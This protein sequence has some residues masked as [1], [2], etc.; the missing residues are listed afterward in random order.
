[1]DIP[2]APF[3]DASAEPLLQQ[4]QSMSNPFPWTSDSSHGLE[5]LSSGHKHKKHKSM[6]LPD[7]SF[8]PGSHHASDTVQLSPPSSPHATDAPSAASKAKHGHRRT[9]S[10]L[11]GVEPR[12]SP[13][14]TL[15]PAVEKTGD[16]TAAPDPPASN[17]LA[18]KKGHKHRRSAAVSKD[19]TGITKGSDAL[20]ASDGSL[21]LT[22]Q[23][24]FPGAPSLHAPV[25]SAHTTWSSSP[26]RSSFGSDTELGNNQNLP[27]LQPTN[28][29]AALRP[30]HSSDG[31]ATQTARPQLSHRSATD[32]VSLQ[33]Y[34]DI[35]VEDP[36]FPAV[37]IVEHAGIELSPFA[38]D[39]APVLNENFDEDPTSTIEISH[40][41]TVSHP[42]SF[43]SPRLEV[44]PANTSDV[45]IDLDSANDV[46]ESVP[47]TAEELRVLRHKSFSAARRSMHSGG[48]DIPTV[49]PGFPM[50]RRTES[51]PSLAVPLV[52]RPSS[53]RTDTAD[54]ASE[55]GFEMENVFEE[56]EEEL[57]AAREEEEQ[58]RLE[59]RRKSEQIGLG[60]GSPMAEGMSP[61][62][63]STKRSSVIRVEGSDGHDTPTPTSERDIPSRAQTI[64][65]TS[66]NRQSVILA[67]APTGEHDSAHGSLRPPT[68]ISEP[69]S[70]RTSSEYGLRPVSQP[71]SNLS[72]GSWAHQQDAS[73][74]GSTPNDPS[75][76]SAWST[77]KLDTA[78]TSVS[79]QPHLHP[80]SFHG[81]AYTTSSV[82]TDGIPSLVSSSSTMS[83]GFAYPG[84]PPSPSTP[85]GSQ[86]RQSTL[87]LASRRRSK[88]ASIASITQLF[89]M[90]R[91]GATRS[92][93]AVEHDERCQTSGGLST[94]SSAA[95][96]TPVK[97]KRLKRIGKVLRFWKSK[98]DIA[99]G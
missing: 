20:V 44:E 43:K 58:F 76:S 61:S 87:S 24:S 94:I 75:Q 11:P 19:L 83:G 38:F 22:P 26:T 89:P 46:T 82:S 67:D 9:R 37:S 99:T 74:F 21:S 65:Q 48:M 97:E 78:A 17:T 25:D 57:Q 95:T 31:V 53:S 16:E 91:S 33:G 32:P 62:D 84:F 51:A 29:A 93:L 98:E 52:E 60:I 71:T 80:P 70:A 13:G 18:P 56:D 47:M 54:T 34:F 3:V 49:R 36:D 85:S 8:N 88:R 64:R 55:K 28:R 63:S 59:S 73:S 5:P 77:P 45:M 41:R 79:D 42:E 90:S 1:M 50:H 35:P 66:S 81:D 68:L 14:L 39:D 40:R 6:A 10:E 12:A 23:S 96:P 27:F 72:V 30:T 2:D 69:D 86:G 7:F 4:S 15:T 92:T